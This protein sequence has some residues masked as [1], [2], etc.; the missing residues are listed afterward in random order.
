[1]RL[2]DAARKKAADFAQTVVA[3]IRRHESDKS[4]SSDEARRQ[5]GAMKR[6]LKAHIRGEEF[7]S[8][9]ASG[10]TRALN[11][12]VRRIVMMNPPFS[13]K[14]AN[15]S[16]RLDNLLRHLFPKMPPHRV[17]AEYLILYF[18]CFKETPELAKHKPIGLC[19]ACDTLFVKGRSDQ[20]YCSDACRFGQWRDGKKEKD[21][22]YFA[23]RAR[24]RRM[25]RTP[26]DLEAKARRICEEL[27]GLPRRPGRYEME[28]QVQRRL[29]SAGFR[30]AKK[31]SLPQIR[32]LCLP[33][34][35]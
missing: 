2:I 29:V 12:P 28:Q 22:D 16:S 34:D 27:G 17:A 21:Q 9:D 19:P 30:R 23:K 24:D 8:R 18:D 25:H 7:K 35:R 14:A 3:E 5:F 33:R 13:G 15:R 31:L 6:L 26:Q 20:E 32:T 4:K 1:M 11:A 10:V